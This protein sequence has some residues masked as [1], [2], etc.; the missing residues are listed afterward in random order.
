MN[1]EDIFS[2]AGPRRRAYAFR[3]DGEQQ[4]RA[5]QVSSP[6]GHGGAML[7]GPHVP[8]DASRWLATFRPQLQ[9]IAVP[10][11]AIAAYLDVCSAPNALV[12]GTRDVAA[13]EV[14]GGGR[15]TASVLDFALPT[16]IMGLELRIL[17]SPG[18]QLG[19]QVFGRPL[20]RGRSTHKHARRP[21]C[22][23]AYA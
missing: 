22:T 1:S 7:H 21:G 9:Q 16:M 17:A 15:C 19:A 11:E 5:P 18:V 20:S 23:R 4:D 12:P 8:L 2:L 14:D 13:R 10:P 3:Q 6:P